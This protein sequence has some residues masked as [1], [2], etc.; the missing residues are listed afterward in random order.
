MSGIELTGVSRWYG[1]VVAVNDIHDVDRHWR[2]RVARAE[3]RGQDHVAAHD[4]RLP[5][6]VPSRADRG[7]LAK[8]ADFE[9]FRT[10]GLVADRDSVYAFLTGT[11][12]VTA[13]ARLHKLANSENRR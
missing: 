13:T 9:I 4:G 3:R 6:P 7:R 10:V 1:N 5:A 11:E 2:H 8:L 12:F